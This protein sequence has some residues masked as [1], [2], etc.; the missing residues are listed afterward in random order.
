MKN[1][2]FTSILLICLFYQEVSAQVSPDFSLDDIPLPTES[3][4]GNI[5]ISNEVYILLDSLEKIKDESNAP[6]SKDDSLKDKTSVTNKIFN[7]DSANIQHYVNVAEEKIEKEVADSKYAQFTK[8]ENPLASVPPEAA[9]D[10][11]SAKETLKKEIATQAKTY[12]E[13]NF[14]LVQNLEQSALDAKKKF[15]SVNDSRVIEEAQKRSSL[16]G[17]SLK[18]RLIFGSNFNLN[19]GEPFTIKI[20]PTVQYRFNKLF[21]VGLGYSNFI[22]VSSRKHSIVL[23]TASL[24]L[25]ANHILYKGFFGNIEVC[26][27]F[28]YKVNQHDIQERSPETHELKVGIG[29]RFRI[30]KK[31]ELLSLV[32]YRI[33]SDYLTNQSPLNFSSGFRFIP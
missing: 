3:S 2:I 27:S 33:Y 11:E 10:T 15:E 23:P 29:K 18:E 14:E 26:R 19:R 30:S 13:K 4:S 6:I 1:I 22:N 17:K 12:I 20:E 7:L 28:A 24:N 5:L 9:T 8:V 16:R 25:F 21:D 32:Q 31:I